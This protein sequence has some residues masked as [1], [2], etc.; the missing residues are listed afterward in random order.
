MHSEI[1]ATLTKEEAELVF[2]SP[3]DN[4]LVLGPEMKPKIVVF[5]IKNYLL[6]H[7][8]IR[9]EG[10]GSSISSACTAAKILADEKTLTI[11]RIETELTEEPK[12][13]PQITLW[14][15]KASAK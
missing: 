4:I 8:E 11:D 7:N 15:S 13:G 6:Y 3:K 2:R 5:M 14:V 9:I 1:N 12:F 10:F